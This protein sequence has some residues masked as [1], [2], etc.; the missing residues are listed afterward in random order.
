MPQTIITRHYFIVAYALN[1]TNISLH[2]SD[3][4]RDVFYV[5]FDGLVQWIIP[6]STIEL[7]CICINGK[8]TREIEHFK[9]QR[10]YSLPPYSQVLNLPVIQAQQQFCWRKA[11]PLWYWSNDLL[12]RT[13]RI[14]QNLPPWAAYIHSGGVGGMLK[15]SPVWTRF[16]DPS[17]LLGLFHIAN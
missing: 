16:C 2:I 13:A 7:Y 14:S 11:K 1:I 17:W 3:W 8:R 12:E 10:L 9:V 6:S 5:A 15:G 4:K